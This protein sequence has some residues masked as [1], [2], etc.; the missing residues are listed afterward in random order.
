M[1][2]FLSII[3]IVVLGFLLTVVC[4]I[5]TFASLLICCEMLGELWFAFI[6]VPIALVGGFSILHTFLAKKMRERLDFGIVKYVLCAHLPSLVFSA[7]VFG[8]VIYLDHIG[9]WDDQLVTISSGVYLLAAIMWLAASLLVGG[10]SIV[11][12][13]FVKKRSA[14]SV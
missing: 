4:G 3:G 12:H 6:V 7:A 9:H 11:V 13:L 14:R 8:N 10:A 2:K 1:K 5:A